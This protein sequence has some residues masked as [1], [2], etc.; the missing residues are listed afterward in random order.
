MVEGVPVVVKKQS[1][2]HRNGV[3]NE[4]ARFDTN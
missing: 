4:N 2:E 3:V 1:K